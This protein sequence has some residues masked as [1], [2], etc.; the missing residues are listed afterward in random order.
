MEVANEDEMMTRLT[1]IL[2]VAIALIMSITNVNA[3]NVGIPKAAANTILTVQNAAATRNFGILKQTMVDEFVWSFGGDGDANQALNAWRKERKY[4]RNLA[5]VTA[6]RCEWREDL[7]EC[8]KN[9]G[10]GYRAG[11]KKTGD[12]WRMIYFVAGD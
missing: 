4:L 8:P 3:K 5:R 7:I 9:A 2:V 12:C 11:F 6:S 1:Y 10:T